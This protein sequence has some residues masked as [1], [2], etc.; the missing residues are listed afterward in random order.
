M[1]KQSARSEDGSHDNRST[2]AGL[3]ARIARWTE[4]DER[5]TSAVPGLMLF[6]FD[7]PTEPTGALYEPSVCVLAHGAKRV[8][9]GDETYTYNTDHYLMTSVHLPTVVQVRDAT[10]ENPYL[11]LKLTFD[12]REVAQLMVD[13]NLPAPRAQP[14][15]HGMGIGS[16]TSPLLEAFTRLIDLLDDEQDIPI[17]A[18]VIHK[19]IIYRLLTGD[20]GAHLRHV[21]STG[22]QGNHIAR[23]ISWLQANYAEPLRIDDLANQAGMSASTF[24]QHF[25]TLT[26]QS[27]LQYQKHLRLQE[28]RRLMLAEQ[29][30]A[31]S[32]AFQVG[33]ESPSQFS[34]E[35]S[36]RFGAPPLRDIA[37]LR[38]SA[39]GVSTQKA[40]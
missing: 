36:R 22:S 39:E 1:T 29:L 20:Q 19:E 27:P 24:H 12:L 17:L 21:A 14:S 23:A 38:Q 18:P 15:S 13:S 40:L 37:N 25:K 6:R 8:M 28:A 4:K 10:P 26:A 16:M 3:A 33:Y 34:R 2:L 5:Y 7:Q 11:G 30:D 32:A 35:Y 31:S 9:L